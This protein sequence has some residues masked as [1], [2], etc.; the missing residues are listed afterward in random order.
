LSGVVGF[1]HGI[2]PMGGVAW[3]PMA[4]PDCVAVGGYGKTSVGQQHHVPTVSL[5]GKTGK[6]MDL[7]I[8]P[9]LLARADEVIE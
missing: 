4:G 5:F 6:A 2:A 1:L 7:S 9:T 8:P 3:T